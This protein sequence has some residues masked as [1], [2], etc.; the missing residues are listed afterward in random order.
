MCDPEEREESREETGTSNERQEVHPTWWGVVY[1]LYLN[2]IFLTT[3]PSTYA[4]PTPLG[5]RYSRVKDE[6]IR[7]R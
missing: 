4:I 1:H 5:V 7:E 2:S 3:V 6:K